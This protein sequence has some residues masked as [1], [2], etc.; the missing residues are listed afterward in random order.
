MVDVAKLAQHLAAHGEQ[1]TLRELAGTDTLLRNVDPTC[2]FCALVSYKQERDSA[3]D[4]FTLDGP[5][6][7]SVVATA[8]A[9]SVE[10]LWLECA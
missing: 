1:A 6:L 5:A 8:T 4:D 10:M 9:A 3:R 7:T 2:V